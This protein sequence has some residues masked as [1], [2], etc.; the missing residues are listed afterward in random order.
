MKKIAYITLAVAALASCN[1]KVEFTQL[2][3]V[4]F[5]SPNVSVYDDTALVKIP[6]NAVADV[7]FAVTFETIDG[8][9]TDAAT[10]LPVPNGENGVD[11]SI[12]DNDAAIL[13]FKAGQQSDTI[14]VKITD[15]TGTL[16]G[17]KEFTIK[18]LGVSG[19]EVSLGGFSACKV[20]IID[21]DHPLKSILGAYDAKAH[22]YFDDVN[23]NW[24]MTLVA[25]PNDY[26]KVWID[27]LV[28]M[29]AGD[30]LSG[31]EGKNHAVYATFNKND[32]L[33][34]DLSSFTIPGGQKLTDPYQG[35]DIFIMSF[36]GSSIS[37]S[38]ITF[39]SNSDGTGYEAN[40]GYG[41]YVN[42]NGAT[43][44][45][46]LLSPSPSIIKK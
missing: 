44:F 18:L 28:P 2:Q 34:A 29:F 1:R 5:A 12:V 4:Y 9:K 17:N 15:F 10:G 19:G 21:N 23:V 24:T 33:T 8:E 40:S 32:D 25:D 14:K 7:D 35:Y 26:Y 30:Y 42:S 13:R 46:E 3:F 31:A 45:F 38:S 16:T 39:A 37:Q 20:T 22:D 11:Y 6:V 41:A 43:G 27:G 36:S